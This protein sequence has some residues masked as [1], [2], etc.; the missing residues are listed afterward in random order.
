MAVL[1]E[2]K[3]EMLCFSKKLEML[4]SGKNLDCASLAGDKK[5]VSLTFRKSPASQMGNEKEKYSYM[6]LTSFFFLLYLTV[7]LIQNICS[8][9]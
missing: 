8:N 1:Y 5:N 4:Y 2:I 7:H 3:L 6:V 9:M